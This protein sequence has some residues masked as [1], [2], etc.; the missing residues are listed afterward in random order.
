MKNV[1]PSKNSILTIL[2]GFFAL[3][4]Q[5]SY[6]QDFNVLVFHET[7][8]FRHTGAI[9]ASIAML[10]D[11]GANADHD[12]WSVDDTRDA[13]VF[14]DQNLANYDV[15]IFSNTS[16]GDLL[17]DN[18]KNAME[19]FI[20]NGGGF[21]G[22][23]AASDTYRGTNAGSTWPWYNELVGAIVQT[24]PYH[25]SNNFPGMMNVLVDHPI[26]NHIGNPGDIWSHE[27]EWYYWELNGGQLSDTNFDLLEVQ[28]TGN[29]SYDATR[30]ITWLKEFDG[31]RSFYTALGHNA[32][33]YNDNETF[34]RMIEKAVL[35][36]ADRL[37]ANEPVND[38]GAT[39]TSQWTD[40]LENDLDCWEIWMGVPHS[41]TGLPG[42]SDNVTNGS[43]TP[44][45]LNNDPRNVFSI[46]E[47]NGEKQL[48]ITGEVYGG[49]TTLNEFENYHLS[50][51]FKWGELKWEPRLNRL[52]DSGI[53]YHCNGEHGTFWDVWKSSLEF[54]VQEGDLGDYIG[55]AGTKGLVPSENR[56]GL[57]FT[58]M[59]PLNTGTLI[60]AGS[61][62]EFPNGEWNLLEVIVIGDRAIHYVNGVMVN[63]LQDATWNGNTVT[64]GQI[65]I[66]SEGAELYYRNIRIKSE[67]EFPA[68]DVATLGWDDD[69]TPTPTCDTDAPIGQMIALKK[70]GGDQ[71]WVTIDPSNSSLIAN[72]EIADRALFYIEEHPNGCIALKSVATDKYV[73]VVRNSRTTP[74]RA[75]G[76]APGTWE[77]FGWE[78]KGNNQ[79][80][81]KSLFNNGW[82][83]ANWNIN[84]TSLFPAGNA[85]GTWET[86]DFE[87]I[88][89]SPTTTIVHITKRNAPGFALDGDHGGANGQNVYLWSENS[90]NVNQQ[91]IEIDRGNGYYSYQKIGTNYCI[92]GDHDGA[93]GQNVYLWNCAENN[94]NQHWLKVDVGDGA[95]QLVKRNASGFA[96]NGGNAGSNAQNVNLYDSSNTSQNLHWI[97]TPIDDIKAPEILEN[98]NI[99]L[100][101][102]PAAN[103]ITIEGASNALVRIYDINGKVVLN[104]SLSSE[105]EIIDIHTFAKGMY[106]LKILGDTENKIIKFVKL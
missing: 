9:N 61:N 76:N 56:N 100:Y 34:R 94:Q 84:N 7:N 26:I 97:I 80:A 30:P 6:A 28:A 2:Y 14:T 12:T 58:P 47:E 90:S 106:Y 105:N 92:D 51:E 59:A 4:V 8:G 17:D 25:T 13:S 33:T 77:N 43:G 20:Q 1:T 73:Q 98:T 50:M 11:L 16:G 53:L 40:L 62:P 95:F 86:F 49:L 36:V 99:I 104:K 68:E 57:T 103:S 93:N 39:L 48:Y 72:G 29:Q 35:W 44:L 46:I 66:Q 88:D 5:F 54:Q 70:S 10:E 21:V 22:F 19:T 69:T 71:K 3:L 55:L 38:C 79:V 81:L 101:P 52:R 102:N 32:T 15:I 24:N 18:Q 41:T 42:A 63:A 96:I 89:N 82:V 60:R 27:E 74:I 67:T 83:Q 78:P 31:G 45:G 75:T 87:I 65:Q 91:W 85:D 23:H 64:S 37:D